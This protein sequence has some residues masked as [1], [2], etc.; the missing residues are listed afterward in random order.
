MP[1]VTVTEAILLVCLEIQRSARRRFELL[2]TSF[3]IQGLASTLAEIRNP[4]RRTRRDSSDTLI[5]SS[6]ACAKITQL[7]ALLSAKVQYGAELK[8]YVGA[9][10]CL[11]IS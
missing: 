7:E 9:L 5:F 4:K 6:Q 3:S 1:S 10:F 11:E 8:E 2:P